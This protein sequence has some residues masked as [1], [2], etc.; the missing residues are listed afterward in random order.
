MS[1]LISSPKIKMVAVKL[2]A[3]SHVTGATASLFLKAG[4]LARP[5]RA[6]AS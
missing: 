3:S 2:A 6:T 1:F 5:C 4:I